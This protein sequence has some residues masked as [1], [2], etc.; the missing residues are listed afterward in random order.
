MPF[1][2]DETS[3]IVDWNFLLF[4][5]KFL[6]WFHSKMTIIYSI[7]PQ[8]IQ[9]IWTQC[10]TATK[11]IV[12]KKENISVP[13]RSMCKTGVKKKQCM[14][15]SLWKSSHL[16]QTAH[17]PIVYRRHVVSSKKNEQKTPSNQTNNKII[18]CNIWSGK[19]KYL[20]YPD[21]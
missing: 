18:P 16:N 1:K 20:Y 6:N 10:K 17:R 14:R 12:S 5:G 15:I 13:K 7:C 4:L 8:S 9:N 2:G 11:V 19:E 3:I 21:R